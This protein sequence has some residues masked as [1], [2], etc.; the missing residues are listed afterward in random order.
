MTTIMIITSSS[1]NSGPTS[2]DITFPNE[3]RERLI[4]VASLNRSP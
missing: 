4:L 2:A 3:D 1:Q